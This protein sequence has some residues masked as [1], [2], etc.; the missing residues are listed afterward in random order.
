MPE[1]PIGSA[2]DAAL[3]AATGRPLPLLPLSGGFSFGYMQPAIVVEYSTI[4]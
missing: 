4:G 3:V 2:E 1:S